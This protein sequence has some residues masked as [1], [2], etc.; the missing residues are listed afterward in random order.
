[1]F[2]RLVNVFLKLRA[3]QAAHLHVIVARVCEYCN[4]VLRGNL[5]QEQEAKT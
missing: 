1:M 5:E 2:F 4:A 3:L